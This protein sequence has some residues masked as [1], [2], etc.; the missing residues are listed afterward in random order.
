MRELHRIRS[1]ES[2]PR[3]LIADDSTSTSTYIMVDESG[4]MKEY[5]DL[6]AATPEATIEALLDHLAQLQA[7]D[8]SRYRDLAIGGLTCALTALEEGTEASS[9]TVSA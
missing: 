8:N 1:K 4:D 5:I 6:K 7:Q 2:L 3:V 9:K